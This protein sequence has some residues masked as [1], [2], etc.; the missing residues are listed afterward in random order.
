MSKK[1]RAAAL[2]AQFKAQAEKY[3]EAATA[4]VS[5]PIPSI[6][7]DFVFHFVGRRVD[8]NSLL[9][10][11]ELP[12]SMARKILDAKREDLSADKEE[13]LQRALDEAAQL[14]LE[15][16][17]ANIEFQKRIALKVCLEPK[18]VFHEPKDETEIDLRDVPYAGELIVALFSWAMELSPGVPVATTEGKETTVDAVENFS[19]Q[20]PGP[21]LPESVPTSTAI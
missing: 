16:K 5:L 13:Q 15:E 3:Q 19:P 18:L 6:A 1:E 12:E 10:A 17:Q 2:A 21:K 7:P 9:I 8:M 14:T 20:S 4:E 11:G